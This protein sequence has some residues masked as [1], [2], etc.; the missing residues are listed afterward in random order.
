[1]IPCTPDSIA[2]AR[3]HQQAERRQLEHD[4]GVIIMDD[5]RVILPT[6]LP[7]PCSRCD[8]VAL[9]DTDGLTVRAMARHLVTAHRP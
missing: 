7:I 5:G 6:V 1:M 4:T 2:A 9:E 8:Y 3:A